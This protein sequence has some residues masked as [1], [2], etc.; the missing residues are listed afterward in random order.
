MNKE[1][2]THTDNEQLTPELICELLTNKNYEHDA[3]NPS[4][5]RV[6]GPNG[7]FFIFTE[8]QPWFRISRPATV[9]ESRDIAVLQKAID[10]LYFPDLG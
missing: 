7:V 5:I 9:R 8:D 10:I 4:M 1:L 2:N 6:H 3:T